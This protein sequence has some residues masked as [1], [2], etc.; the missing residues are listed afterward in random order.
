M[1]L[2]ALQRRLGVCR[3]SKEDEIRNSVD[4]Y[5]CDFLAFFGSGPDFLHFRVVRLH[6]LMAPH[7]EV[8]GRN[9]RVVAFINPSVAVGA[10]EADVRRMY[11][12]IERD[13]LRGYGLWKRFF[14]PP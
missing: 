8:G 3:M 14:R 5:P 1:T 13:G 10:R 12:V 7:A 6:R 4:G 11:F 2:S 9:L